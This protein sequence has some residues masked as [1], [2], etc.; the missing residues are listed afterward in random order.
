MT[1]YLYNDIV[2]NTAIKNKIDTITKNNLIMVCNKYFKNINWAIM[3][4][5]SDINRIREDF[6]Y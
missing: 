5:K 6:F 4:N 2:D 1:H 3:G